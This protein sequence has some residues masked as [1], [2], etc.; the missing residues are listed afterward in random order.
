MDVTMGTLL[1]AAF[2]S[3]NILSLIYLAM[4]A[5]GMAVPAQPRRLVWRLCV[6]PLLAILLISQYS[7]FI[8]LPPFFDVTN[9]LGGIADGSSGWGKRRHHDS[10]AHSDSVKARHALFSFRQACWQF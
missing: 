2:F 1:L 10:D 8:G 9:V 3:I 5:I 4:I 6:L 7:V